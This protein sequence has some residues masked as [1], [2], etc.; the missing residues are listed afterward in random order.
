[1]ARCPKC[2]CVLN[3]EIPLLSGGMAGTAARFSCVS[4][5]DSTSEMRA[6]QSNI[7]G[8][9]EENST[10]RFSSPAAHQENCEPVSCNPRGGAGFAVDEVRAKKIRAKG[11]PN[12]HSPYTGIA[13]IVAMC[14]KG[15]RKSLQ[16]LP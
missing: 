15:I 12:L 8:A 3:D 2:F 13:E 9:H 14:R 11:H 10:R 7:F 16:Q 1:M 4:E 5:P 6:G